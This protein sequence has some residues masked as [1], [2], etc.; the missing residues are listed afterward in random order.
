MERADQQV[1]YD[2]IHSGAGF[3]LLDHRLHG[4][5]VVEHSREQ[6]ADDLRVICQGGGAECHIDAWPVQTFFR[7]AR[8]M[9]V[10]LGN[11][12]VPVRRS[13][14]NCTAVDSLAIDGVACRRGESSVL[15]LEDAMAHLECQLVHHCKAGDHTIFIAQVERGG[16]RD[17]RPLLFFGGQFAQLAV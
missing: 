10:I 15:L 11:Q 12:K 17:G 16:M 4:G 5:A 6:N 8:E 9:D 3:R 7:P 2:A 1:E 14:V 13:D